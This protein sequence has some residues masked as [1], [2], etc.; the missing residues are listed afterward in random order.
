MNQTFLVKNASNTESLTNVQAVEAP[1]LEA[2]Q[3]LFPRL[4]F[5]KAGLKDGYAVSKMTQLWRSGECRIMG[6]L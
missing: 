4:Q 6:K 2:A 1:S 5:K 3:K